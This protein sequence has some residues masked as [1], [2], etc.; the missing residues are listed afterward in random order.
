ME[1]NVNKAQET[2]PVESPFVESILQKYNVDREAGERLIVWLNTAM[3]KLQKMT[4]DHIDLE[5][6]TDK[7]KREELEKTLRELA[8]LEAEL[9]KKI[10]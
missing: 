2:T 8:Q 9:E 10:S 4:P 3:K 6:I 1:N 7:A 5:N